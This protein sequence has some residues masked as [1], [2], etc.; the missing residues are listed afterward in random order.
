[1]KEGFKT[2]QEELRELITE[3]R[4]VQAESKVILARLKKTLNGF[5]IVGIPTIIAFFVTFVSN[6]NRMTT[7]A[8]K[9][10][11]DIQRFLDQHNVDPT[12]ISTDMNLNY[13]SQL[14]A[15]ELDTEYARHFVG[16]VTV[17]AEKVKSHDPGLQ[18]TVDGILE[19]RAE[20]LSNID[21]G[22]IHPTDYQKYAIYHMM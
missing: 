9:A 1:M 22:K 13:A 12:L 5:L 16:D 7:T 3:S 6:S 21:R 18:E 19:K 14:L 10:V 2:P 15:E 20:T 4:L 8:N 17:L 11:C